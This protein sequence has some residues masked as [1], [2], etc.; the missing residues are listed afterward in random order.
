M[1]ELEEKEEEGRL[2]Q[3]R[4]ITF[5]YRCGCLLKSLKTLRARVQFAF[6]LKGHGQKNPGGQMCSVK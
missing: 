5:C 6:G 3:S 2:Q 4:I 1:C